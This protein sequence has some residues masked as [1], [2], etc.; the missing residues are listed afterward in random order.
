LPTKAVDRATL[1]AN[2]LGNALGSIVTVLLQQ[3]GDALGEQAATIR[4]QGRWRMQS[5]PRSSGWV[6]ATWANGSGDE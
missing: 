5:S 6:H 1:V 2:V 3:H 4:E